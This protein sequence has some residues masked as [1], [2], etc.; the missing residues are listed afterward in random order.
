MS[1]D[2]KAVFNQVGTKLAQPTGRFRL[3]GVYLHGFVNQCLFNVRHIPAGFG[4]PPIGGQPSELNWPGLLTGGLVALL[5]LGF[6][7]NAPFR[8]DLGDIGLPINPLRPRAGRSWWTG[9]EKRR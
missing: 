9:D 4:Y 7:M 3:L 1:Q 5:G 2:G 8:P 6:L